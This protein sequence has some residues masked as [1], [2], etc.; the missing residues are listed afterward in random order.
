MNFME[1]LTSQ[2]KSDL[3][4]FIK[5]NGRKA[6]EIKRAQGILLLAEKC[7]DVMVLSVTGL[8]RT[9]VVKL[10]KKYLK[11]GIVALESK[12][13]DKK[14]RAKL[15]KKQRT[16]VAVMLNKETPEKYGWDTKI[17]TPTILGRVILEVFGVK[18]KSKT[19]IR[20]LFKEAKLTY[21]KPEKV[22]KKRNQ[23]AI[24]EW[25]K[26]HEAEVLEALSDPNTV[27][28]AEDEMIVTS[29][30][31]L[32]KIWLPAGASYKVE[33]SNTRKRRSF[34]GFLN[35]KTGAEHA[36]KAEKQTSE[37]SA[38][39]LKK[40]IEIYK[41]KRVLLFW[42]NA[43]WHRGE[44]MRS[45]LSTCSNLKIINFPPYAPD[46]NPQEHVWKAGRANATHN[47]FVSNIDIVARE[48]LGYLN[49]STFKYTFFGFTAR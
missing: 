29:Q 48:L 8:Q 11:S 45:F 24:D 19:P 22:Y 40:I 1:K 36:F 39:F 21:H 13:E 4:A 35:I 3:S 16:A 23:E 32:Q 12:R 46:E 42:D 37:I 9:T 33:S 2:Q 25:K 31:T 17:W 49:N 44:A 30:T 10:R 14:P 7:S 38:K 26:E 20:L 41:D 43:P 27:I 34:F 28:L 15:T 6:E 47:K 18:Y 5:Q